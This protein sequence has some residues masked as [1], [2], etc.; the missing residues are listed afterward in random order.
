[1]TI[2]TGGNSSETLNSSNWD[3]SWD[4]F[5]MHGGNDRVST[6]STGTTYNF[7]G[8]DGDDYFLGDSGNDYISGGD[9]NDQLY[10][11]QGSDTIHGDF[12]NDKC[13]GGYGDDYLNGWYGN[14]RL[15]GAKDKDHYDGGGGT[16]HFV[17]G[18]GH[19]YASRYEADVIYD[20][21]AQEDYIDSPLRG[22]AENYG[23]KAAAAKSIDG[24]R[25]VAENSYLKHEDHAFVY[26]ADTDTGYLLS[27]LDRNGSF[28]TGVILEHVGSASDM[29]WSDI[30]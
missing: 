2:Y 5:V 23:E 6:P 3:Y 19:S 26:N 4:T 10:G 7:Y 1:M 16:D 9:D 22:T 25:Q 20:W 29:N 24:A 21:N 13:V 15:I 8:L 17:I 12:G 11:N 18:R 27:D 28:E 30:V 14:D